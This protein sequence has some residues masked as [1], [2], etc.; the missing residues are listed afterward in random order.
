MLVV[1]A[2]CNTFASFVAVMN[3][4]SLASAQSIASF[5]SALE[6]LVRIKPYQNPASFSAAAKPSVMVSF[7]TYVERAMLMFGSAVIDHAMPVVLTAIV[8]SDPLAVPVATAPKPVLA[9]IAAARPVAMPDLLALPGDVNV[10]RSEERR[11]GEERTA[12]R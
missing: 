4:L 11:V 3:S 9:V 12:E 6:R 8:T 1:S 7:T 10:M 5:T 2:L